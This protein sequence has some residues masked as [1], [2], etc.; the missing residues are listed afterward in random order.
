M[1]YLPKDIKYIIYDYEKPIDKMENVLHEL[2]NIL[3]KKYIGECDD[4]RVEGFLFSAHLCFSCLGFYKMKYHQVKNK[5]S[6]N[7]P[8]QIYL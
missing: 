6:F 4:C 2:S 3:N 7:K 1:Q 5:Y 8:F